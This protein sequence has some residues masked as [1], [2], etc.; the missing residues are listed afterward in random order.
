MSE[1]DI[2]FGAS[3]SL[4][5]VIG[6]GVLTRVVDRDTVDCELARYV[7]QYLQVIWPFLATYLATLPC[8]TLKCVAVLELRFENGNW[9]GLTAVK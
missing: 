5:D 2:A 1:F 4:P 8:S 9:S 3:P 7:A 6:L